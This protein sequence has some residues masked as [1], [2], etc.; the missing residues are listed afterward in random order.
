MNCTCV[1]TG[2]PRD[3]LKVAGLCFRL[4]AG[5]EIA[6]DLVEHAFAEGAI[7]DEGDEK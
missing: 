7:D 3:I 5:S 4:A 1:R 2:I 6:I